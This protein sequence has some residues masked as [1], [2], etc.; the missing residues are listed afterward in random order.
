MEQPALVGYS[1]W[2][3]FVSILTRAVQLAPAPKMPTQIQMA[4]ISHYKKGRHCIYQTSADISEW[5]RHTGWRPGIFSD[6]WKLILTSSGC[7][8][9]AALTITHHRSWCQC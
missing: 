7:P 4:S 9:M 5:S 1:P 3:A 2:N 8:S 6:G